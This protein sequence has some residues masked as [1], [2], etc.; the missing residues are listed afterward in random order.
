M[1]KATVGKPLDKTA[2]V[3]TVP[4]NFSLEQQSLE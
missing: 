4:L 3:L 1:Y 2:V